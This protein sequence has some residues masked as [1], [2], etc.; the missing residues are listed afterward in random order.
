MGVQD[1]GGSPQHTDSLT[2]ADEQ[3]AIEALAR[4]TVEQVAPEELP[5]FGPTTQAYF[6]PSRAQGDDGHADEM[7][8]FGID[9]AAAAVL[10]TP[11]AL[12]AARSTIAFIVGEL[13]AAFKDEAKPMIRSLMRR[14]LGRDDA[15]DAK[16]EPEAAEASPEAT[17]DAEE[18]AEPAAKSRAKAPPFTEPQLREVRKVALR[19]AERMGMD[20]DRAEV[21]ADAIVGAIVR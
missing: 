11:V 12:E 10:V 5:L 14:L 19:T 1:V 9:A 4:A 7:L 15:D 13:Q 20:R 17:T 21:V 16:G 2:D 3:G 8:G 18:P 6:D